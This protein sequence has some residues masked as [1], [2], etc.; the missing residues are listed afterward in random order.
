M[1]YRLSLLA[2]VAVSFVANSERV[3]TAQ[4]P[5]ARF[6]LYVSIFSFIPDAAGDQFRLLRLRI[7]R[8]FEAKNPAVELR[9][10]ELDSSDDP[11]TVKSDDPHRIGSWLTA[12]ISD[13]PNKGGLHL[14]EADMVVLGELVRQNLIR[15]WDPAPDPS[16]WH[17][18]AESAVRIDGKTYGMPHWLCGDFIFSRREDIAKAR[19]A[20]ELRAALDKG[21][22]PA[23]LAGRIAGSW[24]LASLYLDAYADTYGAEHVLDGVKPDLDDQAVRGLNTVTQACTKDGANACL[25]SE[26]SDQTAAPYLF[27]DRQADAVLGYS[28]RLHYILRRAGVRE[29]LYFGSAP[30]G[31]GNH[32]LLFVDAFVLRRDCTGDCEKAAR[33]FTDYMARPDT[34]SWILMSEDAGA[35]RVPRYLLPATKSAYRAKAVEADRYYMQMEL[36]TKDGLPYPNT[37]FYDIRPALREKLEAFLRP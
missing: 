16:D 34:M 27:A 14:V 37:K 31:A 9:M 25:T 2:A 1:K 32:P 10:K 3:G 23:H 6:P 20:V 35:T 8:E 5:K 13:D 15:P 29:K 21:S 18:A 22:T 28:E 11:Y 12:P 24:N 7:K 36:M 33:G 26:Y 19:N 30:L 17:R 4:P